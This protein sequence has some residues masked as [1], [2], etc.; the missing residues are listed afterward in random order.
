MMTVSLPG[1]GEPGDGLEKET[2]PVGG[3]PGDSEQSAVGH[4]LTLTQPLR[5]RKIFKNG[6]F[7][8]YGVSGTPADCVKIALY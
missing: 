3:G 4:A 2:S 1:S 5:V 8:G 6:E 7:F